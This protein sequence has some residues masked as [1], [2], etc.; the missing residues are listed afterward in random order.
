[1]SWEAALPGG[2]PHSWGF[3]STDEG[4]GGSGASEKREIASLSRFFLKPAREHVTPA[5]AWGTITPVTRAA[6]STK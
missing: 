3:G 4:Y 6:P 2:F 1:M 5:R